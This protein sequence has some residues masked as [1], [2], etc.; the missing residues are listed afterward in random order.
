MLA[1]RRAGDGLLAPPR[2]RVRRLRRL[3]QLAAHG[4][5]RR[6]RRRRFA[7]AVAATAI[8]AGWR[9]AAAAQAAAGQA[10]V[11]P[12]VTLLD[13]GRFG[14]AQAQ[15]RALVVVFW[16]TTCP[17]CRRHNQHLEKLHRAAAGHRLA[18]LG[19]A[20]ERDADA[21][22]R[23]AGEHGYTFAITL[24]HAPLAAALSAR[25]VV[26]LTVTVDRGGR[27]RQAIP[28]EMFESDVMEL[29]Q[30]ADK[31]VRT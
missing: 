18:V 22:R 2:R 13:G 6:M 25:R 17:F 19:V 10:V 3:Q 14:P 5:E 15:G 16:S 8:P 4:A 23:H 20:R 24:D 9:A 21:V 29:L 7:A 28:G 26:P 12:E 27:L 1:A 11:W 31:E 30:L